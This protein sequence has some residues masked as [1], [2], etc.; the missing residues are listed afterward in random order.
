MIDDPLSTSSQITTEMDKKLSIT[1]TI[2]VIDDNI[3]CVFV[4]TALDC[5]G[6]G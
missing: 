4:I 1:Y 3:V 6:I 5:T 2:M